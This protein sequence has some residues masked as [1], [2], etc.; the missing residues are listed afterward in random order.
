M[1]RNKIAAAALALALVTPVVANAAEVKTET[2]ET[3]IT[4]GTTNG[5][6]AVGSIEYTRYGNAYVEAFKAWQ[7]AVKESKEADEAYAAA[8]KAYDDAV[9]ELQARHVA[10]ENQFGKVMEA[11]KRV[12]G[13]KQ[14]MNLNFTSYYV[15]GEGLTAGNEPTLVKHEYKPY[16]RYD[17]LGCYKKLVEFKFDRVSP[18]TGEATPNQYTDAQIQGAIMKY[19][20]DVAILN[21]E[22]KAYNALINREAEAILET[23]IEKLWNAYQ[24]ALRLKNIANAKV[25]PAKKALDDAH[26]L[27]VKYGA[28]KA[29]L[30]QAEK[31]GDLSLVTKTIK[32]TTTTP[33]KDT[34]VTTTTETSTKPGKVEETK[35]GLTAAQRAA[36]E[37]AI[38]DAEVQIQAVK[39]LKETTPKTIAPVA[40]KLDKLVA[41]Q[42]ARL[43]KARAILDANK[44]AISD[45][46]FST[47]YAAEETEEDV[48]A[49]IKEINDSTEE[50]KD[51][52]KE[53]EA[54]QPEVKE[55]ETKE[56]DKKD[57][58][59]DKKEETK[60]IEKTVVKPASTNKSAGSNA[61]TGI[62]GVAGVAGVLA[63]ASVAYAASK[64]N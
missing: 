44:V 30:I 48:D 49:L 63:A 40:E 7:K 25:A 31:L 53:N 17:E 20:G 2:T 39:F 11:Y 46:L 19:N 64:K 51:T 57:E 59:E 22:I 10:I 9:A 61:K 6:D 52:L 35:K 47:A 23:K 12:N 21:E 15:D 45:I 18:K 43:V 13:F 60:V 24:E 26:D 32:T 27:A 14:Q 3:K 50:I 37:K 4:G 56:E 29:T 28:D 33:K 42:K 36:L 5:A 8:K 16:I 58:K 41:E 55:E 54:A 1:K 62:A 38:A 34:T